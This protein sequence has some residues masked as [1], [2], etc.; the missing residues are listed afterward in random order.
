M[1][2]SASKVTGSVLWANCTLLF[3]LTLIPLVIRWVDQAG[4]TSWPVACSAVV[5]TFCTVSYLWLE[6]ALIGA[7]GST[8]RVRH[9]LGSRRKEWISFTF[10]LVAIPLSFFSPY[11]SVAIL[12]IVSIGWLIPDRRFERI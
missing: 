2:Q 1:M 3:W 9:A 4:I 11:L 7:E 8:S 5:L 10:L 12:V 6:R